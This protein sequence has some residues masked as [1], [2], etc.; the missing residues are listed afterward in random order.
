MHCKSC[1]LLLEHSLQKLDNVEK[2]Y[3]D[4]SRGIVTVSY[5]ENIPDE[6]AIESI[7]RENGYRI[8]KEAKLPWFHTDLDT[9]IETIL[10]LA[11]LFMIYIFVKMSGISVGNFG[12]FSSPSFG[13]AFLVGL[14]AGVSSCMA[15]VGGLILSVSAKWN[16]EHMRASKWHRFQPHLYFNI[17]RITGFGILGGLL[18]VF[19]F[20]VSLSPFAIGGLTIGSGLI[21]L[22]LGINLSELSPRLSQVSITLPKFLGSGVRKTDGASK[23]TVAL[24]TGALTFFLPCGFTL[25]MQAYAITTG[26]FTTGALTMMAFALGTAPGLLGVGGLTSYLS[27]TIAKK[28]FKFTGILVLILALFNI[29]NG[30]ILMNLGGLAKI[31]P[32]TGVVSDEVQEIRMTESDSGYTPSTLSIKP[33]MHTRWIINAT[34]PYTCAS[35]LIVPSLGIT[36]QL[37]PGENIIEFISPASGTIGFSCSMGMYSGK[38]LI[39][40][41][42]KIELSKDT[43]TSVISSKNTLPEKTIGVTCSTGNNFTSTGTCDKGS[44]ET[45]TTSVSASLNPPTGVETLN[46]SYTTSGLSGNIQVKKGGNYKIVIDVKDTISGCMSTILIPGL[47]EHIQYL[48]G[49]TQVVFNIQPQE[50]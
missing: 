43:N 19:G 39:T 5:T 2:V 4:Q 20:F 36:K 24:M 37:E 1:E 21:M 38:I 32:T 7:I 29:S 34:N 42:A 6:K 47:D 13:V 27:G 44:I 22:L 17:G 12:N 45:P 16:E 25:A 9:Y 23:H 26:S 40:P 3:A 41:D 35:Q 31:T 48:R 8:G 18:G 46:L 10:I 14:T 30:Y 11:V 49:G 15:L 33:N 50:T 28:F